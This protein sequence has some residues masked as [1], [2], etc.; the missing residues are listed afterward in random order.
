MR[1][2]TRTKRRKSVLSCWEETKSVSSRKR[3]NLSSRVPGERPTDIFAKR[4]A[5][6]HPRPSGKIPP[7]SS[8]SGPTAL[9]NGNA[10]TR[11]GGGGAGLYARTH[12]DS[13]DE[14]PVSP[15]GADAPMHR[16]YV[17]AGEWSLRIAAC[18]E[19]ERATRGE[20]R[21]SGGEAAYI[22]IYLCI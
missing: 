18:R 2:E 5:C 20:R 22:Y 4:T 6:V 11:G 10:T 14:R 7:R 1:R 8:Y 12:A 9:S 21:R 13:G 15:P 19:N 17:F 3:G 16:C